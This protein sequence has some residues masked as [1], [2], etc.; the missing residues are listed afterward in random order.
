MKNLHFYNLKYELYW[1]NKHRYPRLNPI[2]EVAYKVDFD[3]KFVLYAF[4]IMITYENKL[5]TYALK[6]LS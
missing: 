6:L 1:S 5:N 2:I 4:N 3:N